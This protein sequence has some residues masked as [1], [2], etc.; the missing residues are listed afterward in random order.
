MQTDMAG[1][2]ARDR[3]LAGIGDLLDSAAAGTGRL[4]VI[5]GGVGVGKSAL[6]DAAVGRAR[7]K[8]FTVL[9]ARGHIAERD[10]RFGVAGR[11]FAQFEW[12]LTEADRA[13]LAALLPRASGLIPAQ[14]L[15]RE[16]PDGAPDELYVLH[17]AL[18]RLAA[19]GPV[20]V[21]VDDLQW[22]DAPS[23]RWLSD[24][25]VRVERAPV[26]L[27]IG[28]SDGEPGAD[29]GLLDELLAS[30]ATEIRPAALSVPATA[31]VL[32]RDLGVAPDPRFAT[33]CATLTGGNPLLLTT[34]SG[35]LVEQRITPTAN[36]TTGLADVFLPRLVR[37][38]NV[39]LR[40]VSPHAL[41]VVLAVAVFGAEATLERV[42]EITGVDGPTVGDL[43]GA[44]TRM[45]L[46][47]SV[48]DRLE[49]AQPLLR[50]AV[51]REQPFTTLQAVH[52]Q[53]ARLLFDTGAPRE[54]I[55][56]QLLATAPPAEP[57]ATETLRGA[58][59]AAL[60]AGEADTAV[61]YLRR[62]LAE[63]IL[64]HARSEILA[65]LGRAE[66]YVDLPA[67]IRHLT[68]AVDASTAP[69][70]DA[71]VA[72]ELA[73]LLAITGRYQ[74]AAELAAAAAS[75]ADASR[76]AEL[77]LHRAKTAGDATRLLDVGGSPLP[78]QRS[79]DSRWLSLLA[80]RQ[81]WSGGCP[82]R[83]VS[84]AERALAAAPAIP[85]SLPPALRA[86]DVLAQAGHLDQAIERCD[87][88]VST[89]TRWGHRPALA[90][91][92]STRAVV[93]RQLGLLPA[94]ADDARAG[95]DLLLGCGATR[96]SGATVEYTARL[97]QVL[98]D[99][100]DNDEATCLLERAQL[101]G[102]IQSSWAGAALLFARGRL[103][104]A[105]GQLAAGAQDL[106]ESGRRLAAWEVE[107]PAV[108][109]WRSEAAAA[110][111]MLGQATEARRLA[112]K[113][114]ELARRWGAPGPLGLA[115]LAYARVLDEPSGLTMLG[116]SVSAERRRGS[117]DASICC[118]NAWASASS[119]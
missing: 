112:A 89:A 36:A 22:V 18:N 51:M 46:L 102:D 107:N 87:V 33:E 3:E 92:R 29:P 101:T 54:R 30:S 7:D 109:P 114:A 60:A 118:S 84:L 110:L 100:G 32:E 78:D 42:V 82:E 16:E 6:L 85:D 66:A 64:P 17:R 37:G 117:V 57:W 49:F 19:G 71:E 21:A 27:L 72:H 96:R 11:L 10:I 103:G 20:L 69:H 14:R 44:L 99:L 76:L 83:A 8:G 94:A 111:W 38:L 70:R 45:G 5:A 86:V 58:A 40:R 52:A 73:G 34:L 75:S 79:E 67:A 104:V 55:A 2:S 97:V 81:S 98:V 4:L 115:L 108:V 31:Q 56:E 88:L 74:S 105:A 113:E 90:A 39:R 116:E 47:R 23:L 35:A 26:A 28:I 119:R 41:S 61:G 53:A 1:L 95:L 43:A 59:G 68:D 15:P 12:Q 93:R 50:N 63:P 65:E 91:A 80:A 24:L 48:G 62:A 9:P 106:L 25:A 13:D 77:S